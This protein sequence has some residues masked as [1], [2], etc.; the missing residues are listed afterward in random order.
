MIH[1]LSH[2]SVELYAVN[3]VCRVRKSSVTIEDFHA[4]MFDVQ[5]RP[6]EV[7]K[8]CSNHFKKDVRPLK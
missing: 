1:V 4:S 2:A 3:H 6:L 5:Q 7:E 8:I